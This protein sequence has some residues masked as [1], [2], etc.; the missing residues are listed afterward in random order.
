VAADRATVC[1][2]AWSASGCRDAGLCCMQTSCTSAAIY[3]SLQVPCCQHLAG[4]VFKSWVLAQGCV[5]AAIKAGTMAELVGSVLVPALALGGRVLA[6]LR[7]C[8]LLQAD[9]SPAT[10][11][12]GWLERP[13]QRA[14]PCPPPRLRK[15]IA[16][17]ARCM[18][19]RVA[20]H[21]SARRKRRSA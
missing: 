6:V 17:L 10:W 12:A 18:K 5:T 13:S 2:L 16:V 4:A 19:R 11:Q 8:A 20:A 9:S 15:L 1:R 21:L 14:A 3:H 7:W